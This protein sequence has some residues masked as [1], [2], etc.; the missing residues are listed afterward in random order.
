MKVLEKSNPGNLAFLDADVDTNRFTRL[1]IL[2]RACVDGFKY[3]RPIL[4]LDG[5]IMKSRFKGTL[6]STTTKDRNQG[7]FLF[8][9]AVVS[10][11]NRDNWTWFLEKIKAAVDR[12]VMLVSNR[13]VGLMEAI[14]NV[15]GSSVKHFFCLMH[16]YRNLKETFGG[17]HYS[18]TL[19]SSLCARL[20]A[21]AYAPNIRLFDKKIEIFKS[22]GER[23]LV[24]SWPPFHTRS[25]PLHTA[26][27]IGMPK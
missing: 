12:E 22:E 10:G 7:L 1:F 8:A 24:I 17:R 26:K 21:C 18:S 20:K 23:L 19:R 16:L 4:F 25:G 15:F 14:Q 27:R 5:T 3:C 6:L 9:F 13:N 2:F 11:K